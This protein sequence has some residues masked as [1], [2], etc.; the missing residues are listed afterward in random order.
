MSTVFLSGVDIFPIVF[1]VEGLGPI[2]NIQKPFVYMTAMN[3]A[4][5]YCSYSEVGGI[6]GRSCSFYTAFDCTFRMSH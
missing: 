2:L 1:Y 6:R 3:I 5:R 4:T